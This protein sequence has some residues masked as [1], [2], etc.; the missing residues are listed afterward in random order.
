M[1]EKRMANIGIFYGSTAGNTRGVAEKIQAGFGQETA[2]V[3]SIADISSDDLNRYQYLLFGSSTWGI[4]ELQDD[5]LDG[6]GKFDKVDWAGKKV[7]LFGTGDPQGYPDSFV[8]AIGILYEALTG[9][10]ADVV[11]FWPVDGYEYDASR[12]EKDGRFVG[13][14]IDE[15]NQGDL[16]EERIKTWI[17][18]LKVVMQ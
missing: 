8:D 10:G 9:K 15:D 2:D 4:G 17:E 13:L 5:W 11:G 16:T 1:K 14:V 7:A 12:A 3:Y 18:D 6:V